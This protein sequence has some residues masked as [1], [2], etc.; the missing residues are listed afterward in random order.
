MTTGAWLRARRREMGLTLRDVQAKTGRDFTY[1]SKIEN[2]HEEPGL[3]L[4]TKLGRIYGVSRETMFRRAG[5]CSNCWGTGRTRK[6]EPVAE[7]AGGSMPRASL[8][9][10]PFDRTPAPVKRRSANE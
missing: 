9:V 7:N 3:D 1:L 2:D 8:T 10:G 6:P 4:L 5:R